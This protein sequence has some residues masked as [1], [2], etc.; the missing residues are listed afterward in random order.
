MRGK[1][2]QLGPKQEKAH[3]VR[4]WFRALADV[5]DDI[6]RVTLAGF[7]AA[8]SGLAAARAGKERGRRL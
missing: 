6:M 1:A 5:L 8:G 2:R 4:H 7:W 3:R